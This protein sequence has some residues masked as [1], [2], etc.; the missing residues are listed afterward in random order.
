MAILDFLNVYNITSMVYFFVSTIKVL[1]KNY[2]KIQQ[3]L[4]VV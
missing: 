1:K 2:K 3:L 4:N